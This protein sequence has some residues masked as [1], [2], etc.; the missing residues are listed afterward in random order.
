MFDR[1]LAQNDVRVHFI[2][3]QY[4]STSEVLDLYQEILYQ[5]WKSLEGF[6]G[7]AAPETWAYSIAL[8][9]ASDFRRTRFRRDKALSAYG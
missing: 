6:E 5:L 2:A 3:Q 8:H 4:A 1:V 7:R 9:A